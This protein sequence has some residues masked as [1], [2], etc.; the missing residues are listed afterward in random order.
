LVEHPLKKHFLVQNI[1]ELKPRPYEQK[2]IPNS[3]LIDFSR[4]RLFAIKRQLARKKQ[5]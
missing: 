3:L 2:N 5:L 1:R 4:L